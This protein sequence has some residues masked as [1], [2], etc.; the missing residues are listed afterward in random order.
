M[1]G[2]EG[3]VLSPTSKPFKNLASINRILLKRLEE[4]VEGSNA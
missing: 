1:S 2:V 3:L 4:R